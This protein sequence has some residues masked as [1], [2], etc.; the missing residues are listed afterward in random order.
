[1]P[2]LIRDIIKKL[3]IMLKSK[4]II[5]KKGEEEKSEE[6]K[7]ISWAKNISVPKDP[8]KINQN[9]KWN[10]ERVFEESKKYSS[11]SDFN[12]NSSRAYQ[13]ALQNNWLD[14]MTWLITKNK[15]SGYWTVERVF[16]ESKKYQ[17]RSEFK[18][19][20]SAA[21]D[22]A[23][24]N[25]LLDQM[26]WLDN[27]NRK[28]HGYWTKERV[29]EESKKYTYRNQFQKGCSSAYG[30][31][32]RNKWLDEMTWLR[33]CKTLDGDTVDCIY[34]YRF[35][36]QNAIYIGRTIDRKTR[37]RDHRT[38]TNDAVYIFFTEN[39]LPCPEMEIIEDNL[40]IAE[41]SEREGYWVDYYKK[42]GWII[43]NRKKT[44][45]L[46]AIASGKW[47]YESCKVEASKYS[48]RSEFQK[49][50]SGAY[51]ASLKRGWL[52]EFF[53]EKLKETRKVDQLDLEENL[54]Q[55]FLSIKE[56]IKSIGKGYNNGIVKCC[57]G[58]QKTAGGYKWRYH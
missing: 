2:Y 38:K 55:T 15:P 39:S 49:N 18:Q 1:L 52:D 42:E 5:L 22:K 32:K 36:D 56:A 4:K 16:E 54:I 9:K 51:S 58:K 17:S 57:K 23:R 34:A 10:K 21:F 53:P 29:F 33:D 25:N 44:G 50:A 14:Q 24:D 3:F 35:S 47:Y 40:T 20:S 30:I 31:S 48:S 43:L 19:K 27:P 46:G 45:G 11:R 8:N 12:K 41:G 26:P 28:P 37:D 13:I 6:E 7:I